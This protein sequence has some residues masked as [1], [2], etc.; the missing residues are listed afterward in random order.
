MS[1]DPLGALSGR[2]IVTTRAADQSG[3][4]IDRLTRAGARITF[5][6]MVRFVEA[7]DRSA[8]DRAIA[9]LDRFTWVVYT[10]A[11]AVRF[12]LDRCR[13]LGYWPLPAGLRFAVVGLATQAALESAGLR[14]TFVPSQASG[15][16]LATELAA[17]SY[18]KLAAERVLIPRSDRADDELPA[19]LK[20]AG[21]DV[22]AVV[23]YS[24]VGPESLDDGALASLRRGE[25]DA[26]MFFSPSAVE[27]FAKALGTEGLRG[28]RDRVAFAAIG[29]TTAAAIG[30]AGIPVAVESPSAT[31][32]SLVA[33]LESYFVRQPAGKERV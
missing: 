19:A 18:G 4:L 8:L 15:A 27:E 25:A 29:P 31:T 13:S 20:A 33:A 10:S 12:F 28:L 14:A 11:N 23:A 1:S 9:G 2:V 17:F 3:E 6:P 32:E 22:T 26:V 30:R 5:L 7:T 16:S 21:A 24:T